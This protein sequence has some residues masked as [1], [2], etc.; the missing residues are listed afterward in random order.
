M[1]F[2]SLGCS[3]LCLCPFFSLEWFLFFSLI[4]LLKCSLFQ[5]S[6]SLSFAAQWLCY[7]NRDILFQIFSSIMVYHR[8]LNIV[9]C[10]V[11]RTLL[12]IHPIYSSLYLLIPNSQSFLL[13]LLPSWQ[14]KVCSLCLWVSFCFVDRFICAV[15]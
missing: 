2:I 13:L 7:T 14:L 11:Y 4:F 6:A 10:A 12:L 1:P 15:F 3:C 5:C 8:R 9:P